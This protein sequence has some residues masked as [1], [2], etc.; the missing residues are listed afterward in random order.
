MR[1]QITDPV[2]I[3]D[4][5]AA[6]DSLAAEQLAVLAERQ[7]LA[8]DLHDSVAQSLFSVSQYANA[9]R[10]RWRPAKRMP[11]RPT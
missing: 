1:F 6:L 10:W 8:R 7:R 2:D 3:P 9:A 4:L 5:Q 11:R